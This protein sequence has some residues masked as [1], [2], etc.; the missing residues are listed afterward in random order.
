M[1]IQF[2]HEFQSSL[3]LYLD[4]YFLYHGQASGYSQPLDF[5]YYS[6]TSDVGQLGGF[7]LGAFYCPNKQLVADG[8][9]SGENRVFI[10]G[11]L[12][13]DKWYSQT[14]EANIDVDVRTGPQQRPPAVPRPS[15]LASELSLLFSHARAPR[16]F[17]P[18][19][20]THHKHRRGMRKG[21]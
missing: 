21:I 18:N 11:G 4:N 15:T 10:S 12:Q 7:Q 13:A 5:Q 1:K 19:F 6:E 2:D 16:E 14:T 3:F 20:F 17:L 8:V 9:P